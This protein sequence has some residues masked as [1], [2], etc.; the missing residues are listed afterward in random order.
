MPDRKPPPDWVRD[1]GLLGVIVWEV[2]IGT[3]VGLGLGY[4]LWQKMG[5]PSWTLAL[6]GLLGL[7][8]AMFRVYR[9]SRIK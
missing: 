5:F 3:G 2:L 9:M 8:F 7:A 4:L 1:L 6:T